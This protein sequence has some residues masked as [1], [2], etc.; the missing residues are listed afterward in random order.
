M[1]RVERFFPSTSVSD[2]TSGALGGGA[3]ITA[4]KATGGEIG[5]YELSGTGY[6]YHI[7]Y[8]SGTFTPS[9]V[10]T[11][12]VMI[13]A[14]GGAGAG[15][16]ST[17]AV[18][19]AGAGGLVFYSGTTLSTASKTVVIGAGGATPAFNSGNNG[20]NSSFTGLTTAVG[21]GSGGYGW[22]GS[23]YNGIAGGSG[24]GASVFGGSTNSGG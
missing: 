12:N 7:F 14:G 18:G 20:N 10:I 21:G 9:E 13:V 1:P 5:Y 22:T 4:P 23:N 8:A 15:Y 24:G 16:T 19:G 6:W 2:W 3:G 11:A 17:S